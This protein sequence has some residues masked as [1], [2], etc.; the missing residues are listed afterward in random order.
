MARILITGALGFAGRTL[1]NL[2]SSDTDEI[3]AAY[4]SSEE[5]AADDPVRR[6]CRLIEMDI[7]R[8]T[9]VAAAI[10]DIRPEQLYHLAALVP[11]NVSLSAPA[12]TMDVNVI[13]TVNLLEAVRDS[14]CRPRILMPGSSEEFGLIH[15]HETPVTE[16]Q[17]LRPTNPYGVSK[18]TQTLLG[19]QYARTYGLAVIGGRPFNMTGPGQSTD[20]ACPAFAQ[21]IAMIEAGQTEPLV[22]VGNLSA[23]RDFSDVRDVMRACILLMKHGRPGQTCN[24]CSGRAYGMREVLDKLLALSSVDNIKV[25]EDPSKYRPAD[26]LLVL[27]SNRKLVGA[28]G[29]QPRY[30]LDQ[31]LADVLS[32]FRTR[33]QSRAVSRRVRP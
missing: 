6:H 2:L 9:Q 4:L 23:R 30:G 1:I 15:P 18:A 25:R 26:N 32:D 22:R 7:L 28:T 13:G 29:Y 5:P 12:R 14:S 33:M 24:I 3:Y 10:E 27:G 11:I 8:P 17:P 21:Q 20:Y 16:E 31:T 19:M